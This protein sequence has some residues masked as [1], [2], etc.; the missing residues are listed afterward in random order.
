MTICP[1]IYWQYKASLALDCVMNHRLTFTWEYSNLTDNEYEDLSQS[2]DS[3]LPS[4]DLP[5]LDIT[6]WPVMSAT[7]NHQPQ[8]HP[9][10]SLATTGS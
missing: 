2:V 10:A 7:A 4:Q 5:S 9:T 1:Q 8:G 3:Q 6:V